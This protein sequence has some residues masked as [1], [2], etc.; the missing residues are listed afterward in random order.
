MTE[1]EK[2]ELFLILDYYL[3]YRDKTG[4]TILGTKTWKFREVLEEF[5]DKI[6]SGT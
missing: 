5:I 1:E 2:R 4:E 6:K 3:I